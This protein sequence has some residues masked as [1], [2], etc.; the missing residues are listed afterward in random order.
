MMEEG[1]GKAIPLRRSRTGARPL[2]VQQRGLT[3]S[4]VAAARGVFEPPRQMWLATLGSAG[5]TA[6]GV[7]SAWAR[8]V[9]E[10]EAVEGWLRRAVRR[11]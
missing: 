6:R 10:G 3:G 7:R 9:A 4:V 1:T 2:V 5:L 8:L 11:A